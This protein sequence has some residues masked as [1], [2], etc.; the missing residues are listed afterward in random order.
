MWESATPAHGFPSAV[1]STGHDVAS[2]QWLTRL[3]RDPPQLPLSSTSAPAIL[4][5]FQTE[6]NPSGQLHSTEDSAQRAKEESQ[7]RAIRRNP[8]RTGVLPASVSA[9][10]PYLMHQDTTGLP[11]HNPGPLH[12]MYWESPAGKHLHGDL[13]PSSFSTESQQKRGA[14]PLISLDASDSTT[15]NFV[16][17]TLSLFSLLVGDCADLQQPSTMQSHRM[18]RPRSGAYQSL[19]WRCLAEMV[20]NLDESS[21]FRTPRRRL[22]LVKSA[23][24]S[25]TS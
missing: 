1:Y 18:P 7:G 6:A 22:S 14:A 3:V 25:T 20:L 8:S 24:L 16:S 11:A 9:A 23:S 5:V 2:Q 17:C 4:P 10:Y 19:V 21:T 13:D 15:D 12:P